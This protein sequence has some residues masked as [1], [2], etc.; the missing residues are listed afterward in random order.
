MQAAGAAAL[1][2]QVMLVKPQALG[3]QCQVRAGQVAALA[4]VQA[5]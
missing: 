4:G 1:V 2:A 5:G 3:H